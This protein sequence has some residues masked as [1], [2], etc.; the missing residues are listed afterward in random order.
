MG[1]GFLPSPK[2]VVAGALVTLASFAVWEL[3]GR[4]AVLRVKAGMA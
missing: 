1:K 3:W 2:A 4:E